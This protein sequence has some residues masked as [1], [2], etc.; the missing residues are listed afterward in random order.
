MIQFH[1][2]NKTHTNLKKKQEGTNSFRF[3]LKTKPK[4]FEMSSFPSTST[5]N[6]N[7][8][9]SSHL[10][11]PNYRLNGLSTNG[12]PSQSSTSDKLKKL[13]ITKNSSINEPGTDSSTSGLDYEEIIVTIRKSEKGFGFEIKNGILI[14]KVLPS[15]QHFSIHC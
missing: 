2:K 10:D 5:L 6:G 13:Q 9:S 1:L 15:L 8:V 11:S 12:V 7:N 4:A 14:V 3:N